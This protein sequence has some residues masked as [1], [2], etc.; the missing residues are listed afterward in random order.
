MSGCFQRL[1]FT[2]VLGYN[3]LNDSKMELQTY[4]HFFIDI[5]LTNIMEKSVARECIWIFSEPES[6]DF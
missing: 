6:V 5:F 2:T 1:F 4:M 3:E